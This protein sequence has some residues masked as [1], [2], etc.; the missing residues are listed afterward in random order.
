[1]IFSREERRKARL[2][3]MYSVY[4]FFPLWHEFV[5]NLIYVYALYI[6]YSNTLQGALF[7][8]QFVLEKEQPKFGRPGFCPARATR[9]EGGGNPHF[10]N[11][12]GD[13]VSGKRNKERKRDL[14]HRIIE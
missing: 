10:H 2:C 3:L 7:C 6:I 8:G 5:S 11:Y 12:S 13:S 14:N 4:T 1:M 9:R